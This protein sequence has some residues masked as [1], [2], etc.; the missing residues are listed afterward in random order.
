M[1]AAQSGKHAKDRRVGID[2]IFG[3]PSVRFSG[4]D[5]IKNGTVRRASDH[6]MV[7]TSVSIPGRVKH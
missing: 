6:P 2:W 3:S 4:Y 5:T 7:T 1:S